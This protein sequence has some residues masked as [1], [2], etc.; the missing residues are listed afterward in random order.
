[1]KMT[2]HVVIIGGGVVGLSVATETAARGYEVTLI[3]ATPKT[4]GSSLGNAGMIVPSHFIPLAS[5]GMI[6]LGLKWMA[7][8]ESP[9]Y[10]RPRLSWDLIRWGYRF[11]RACNSDR[12]ARVAPVLRDLHLLSRS[13]YARMAEAGE[14][15]GLVKNG[16]MMLCKTENKWR[17]EVETAEQAGSLGLRVRVLDASEAA[18]LEP[19]IEMDIYGA[20]HYEDDCHLDPS[21]YVSSREQTFIRAGGRFLYGQRVTGWRYYNGVIKAVA[22]AEGEIAGDFFVLAGG[23]WSSELSR[24]LGL[25]LPM[26]AGKGYSVTHPSPVQAPK[27]C[28]ILVE[29]RVAVTPLGERLRFGGTM[30]ISGMDE[31]INTRRV[32][33][34][35]KAIP[36][37]FPA[38]TVED[39]AGLE[40]WHGLRP[41][42]PDGLPYLGRTCVAHNLVIATGHAMM[43]LSLAPVTGQ[44]VAALI[45]GEASPIDLDFFSPDRFG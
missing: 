19:G 28:S 42:P 11:W 33:G 21:R 30:E 20:V 7:N 43:G 9:F 17:E 26:Q 1:M 31:R 45:E 13:A 29:S 5:P 32:A 34:I 39:F 3:D 15:I 6:Y 40:V 16:L 25:R 14:K 24:Q 4:R 22:T 41:C 23:A 44:I 12:V 37:Y 27:T 2:G 8:P 38:F 10:I 18:S 36:R 35:L